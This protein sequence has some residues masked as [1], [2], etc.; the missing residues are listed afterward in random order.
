MGLKRGGLLVELSE[1]FVQDVVRMQKHQW[2]LDVTLKCFRLEKRPWN[3]ITLHNTVLHLII[4][5][6]VMFPH[7][8]L[9]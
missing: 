5:S 1:D 8:N 2:T 7:L 4:L 3:T 6:W 9:L